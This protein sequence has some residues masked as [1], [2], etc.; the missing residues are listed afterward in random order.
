MFKSVSQHWFAVVVAA[1][2]IAGVSVWKLPAAMSRQPACPFCGSR[3]TL[4]R[5]VDAEFDGRVQKNTRIICMDC[6]TDTLGP[7]IEGT[8]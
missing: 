1:A 2:L 7:Y 5:R 8:K 3:N 6:S 4:A